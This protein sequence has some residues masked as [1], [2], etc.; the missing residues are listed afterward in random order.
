MYI[1]VDENQRPLRLQKALN[2]NMREVLFSTY[3]RATVFEKY[4]QAKAAIK[5]SE[6]YAYEMGIM[7]DWDVKHWKILPLDAR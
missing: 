4:H 7:A 5:R 2:W 6:Q 1:V 3:K